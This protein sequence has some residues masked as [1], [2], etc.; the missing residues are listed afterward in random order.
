MTVTFADAEVACSSCE[1]PTHTVTRLQ[2]LDVVMD[3]G[4]HLP[5]WGHAI[6]P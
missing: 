1:Q 5:A 2:H 3:D 6:C 4:T